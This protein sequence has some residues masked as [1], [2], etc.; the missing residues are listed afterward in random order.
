MD[1]QQRLLLECTAHLLC[2]G[3]PRGS[4][5]TTNSSS[6]PSSS[7]SPAARQVGAYIGVASSDYGS[8]VA[9]HTRSPGPLHAT[10][11]A[12]SVVS[13]RLAYVFGLQ[14]AVYKGARHL[15]V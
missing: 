4:A 2:N 12:L 10:S 11:N 6:H 9:Q 8:L 1:P 15:L 5:S 7:I 14:G 3:A 13:G